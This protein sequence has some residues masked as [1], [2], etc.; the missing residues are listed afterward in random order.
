MLDW[1][2]NRQ[3]CNCLI[4]QFKIIWYDILNFP[5]TFDK[6][7][8]TVGCS[9]ATESRPW[10]C[11]VVSIVFFYGQWL[12][13]TLLLQWS[14]PATLR[15]F[16]HSRKYLN[17]FGIDLAKYLPSVT[18]SVYTD[19]LGQLCLL[20]SQSAP[21]TFSYS[22]W[23]V[24]LIWKERCRPTGSL[25]CMRPLS[26]HVAP[27][28]YLQKERGFT[29]HC[30]NDSIQFEFDEAPG[31]CTRFQAF[32]SKQ[33]LS[34]KENEKVVQHATLFLKWV[35]AQYSAVPGYVLNHT[36]SI[37]S[38]HWVPEHI[39]PGKVSNLLSMMM[40]L[41]SLVII[42]LLLGLLQGQGI[43]CIKCLSFVYKLYISANGLMN[44][45]IIS[46]QLAYTYQST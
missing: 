35:R 39:T 6:V 21:I 10:L 13:T 16:L 3:S 37:V 23:S 5:L 38:C 32:A 2:Q 12:P 18:G 7:N 29:R 33:F 27:T 26:A 42:K 36:T 17:P 1:Q 40:T 11:S 44:R 46:S 45:A 20:E 34:I 43:Y 9:F 14:S 19:Q 15:I 31:S 28:Q 24:G 25:V 4:L 41:T 8:T 22:I 30:K